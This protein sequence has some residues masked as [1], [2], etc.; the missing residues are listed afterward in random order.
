M[1]TNKKYRIQLDICSI[2]N[3]N[4]PACSM[5]KIN[6]G[7]VKAGYLTIDNFKLFVDNNKEYIKNIELSNN[8][9]PFLNPDADKILK[10]AYEQHIELTCHNATNFNFKNDNLLKAM[11]DYQLETLYIAIDGSCPETY[12][13]Y[14]RNGDFNFFISNIKKLIN[15]K[16]EKHSTYPKITWQYIIRESTE[17]PQEI[18]NAISLA[19]DLNINIYFKLTWEDSYQPRVEW[20]DEIK[21]LTKL[22]YL[23]RKEASKNITKDIDYAEINHKCRALYNEEK[24]VINW[25]GKWLGCCANKI[26]SNLNVFEINLDGL[27]NSEEYLNTRYFLANSVL[28]SDKIDCF[29]KYCYTKKNDLK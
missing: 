15:Y 14:R 19:K 23:T 3:L 27:F 4:C 5:R 29:C 24:I 26:P 16:K 1:N 6:Y 28:Y 11:V 8:G 7:E 10:Y 2:C 22:P 21:K 20:E 13:L 17:N 12:S 9:E 25:D 18:K